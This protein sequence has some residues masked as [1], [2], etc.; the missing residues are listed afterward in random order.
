MLLF[1]KILQ[2]IILTCHHYKIT[3]II[4]LTA[5]SQFN[6]LMNKCTTHLF[7]RDILLHG[8]LIELVFFVILCSLFYLPKQYF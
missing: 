5:G 1:V 2:T 7:L 6:M 3:V 4:R 8:F